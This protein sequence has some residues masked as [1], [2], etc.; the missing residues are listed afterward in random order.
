MLNGVRLLARS[1]FKDKNRRNFCVALCLWVFNVSLKG[2]LNAKSIGYP[3]HACTSTTKPNIHVSKIMLCIW[4]DQLGVVYYE[5]LKLSKNIT[6][7]CDRTQLC[8]W[9]KNWMTNGCNKT[10]ST[11]KWFFC[12]TM[13]D[14]KL[15]KWSRHTGKRWNRKCYSPA[16]FT[17]RYCSLALSADSI[18][19]VRP[20]WQAL[21]ILWRSQQWDRFVD[22]FKRWPPFSKRDSYTAQYRE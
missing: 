12:M 16:I 3:S 5:L 19:G 2:V 21:P 10:R 20:E 9:A 4:W 6:R 22:L 17:R 14:L 13:L 11:I 8:F 1:C 15:Q 7:R 18:H